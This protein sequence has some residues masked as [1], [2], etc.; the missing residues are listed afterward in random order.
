MKKT[1]TAEPVPFALLSSKDAV[2]NLRKDVAF[3]EPSA[4]AGGLFVEQ[5]CSLM[6]LLIKG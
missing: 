4:Q 5:G 2:R 3:N 1:H 6:D